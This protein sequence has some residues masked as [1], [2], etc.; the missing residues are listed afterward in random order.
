MIFIIFK[1]YVRKSQLF[2]KKRNFTASFVKVSD[3]Q[4]EK[5]NIDVIHL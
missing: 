1:Y 5:L 4:I 3:H 2:L